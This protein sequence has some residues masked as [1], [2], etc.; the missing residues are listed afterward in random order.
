M[1]QK[2]KAEMKIIKESKKLMK[3]I[4]YNI[5]QRHIGSIWKIAKMFND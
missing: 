1:M 4:L 5:K 3:S 2:R